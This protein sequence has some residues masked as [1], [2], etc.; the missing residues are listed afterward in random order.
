M[1]R[2]VGS[3][4]DAVKVYAANVEQRNKRVGSKYGQSGGL[5]S[6]TSENA[7]KYAMFSA[8]LPEPLVS[9]STGSELRQRR[10]N[11]PSSSTADAA[12]VVSSTDEGANSEE[13]LLLGSVGD[14]A[15]AAE[16]AYES[17]KKYGKGGAVHH[18]SATPTGSAAWAGTSSSSSNSGASG[19]LYNRG[20]GDGAAA[21]GRSGFFGVGGG[22]GMQQQAQVQ[23]GRGRELD[24][25]RLQQAEQAESTIAQVCTSVIALACLVFI[26]TV[27]ISMYCALLMCAS[28]CVCTADGPAVR[29]D[30]DAGVGTE[31]GCAAHRGRRRGGPARDAGGAG[32]PGAGVRDHQGQPRSHPEGIRA[33]GILHLS[34]SSVDIASYFVNKHTHHT[35]SVV[36]FH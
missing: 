14:S 31:R 5:S 6:L 12:F 28:I 13:A 2:Y 23:K 33:A 35:P 8:T 34:V 7:S 29:A 25:H 20:K 27:Y 11:A 32:A 10:G 4:K 19:G 3:F 16:D 18:P 9:V 17:R 36:L 21:G 30:G 22:A 15:A 1:R 24:R 26:Y